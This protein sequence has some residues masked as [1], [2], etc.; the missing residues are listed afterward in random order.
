M[1]KSSK[2][3]RMGMLVAHV[4]P[5]FHGSIVLYLFNPDIFVEKMPS[6]VRL[7]IRDPYLRLGVQVSPCTTAFDQAVPDWT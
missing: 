6:A 3:K 5:L 7:E 1:V 4:F 2:S